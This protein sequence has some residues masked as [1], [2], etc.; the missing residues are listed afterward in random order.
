MLCSKMVTTFQGPGAGLACPDDRHSVPLM[1]P[2]S[3]A[4]GLAHIERPSGLYD[5]VPYEAVMP[6]RCYKLDSGY[7]SALSKQNS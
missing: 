2:A 1:A 4:A 7:N 3:E 5:E 6:C